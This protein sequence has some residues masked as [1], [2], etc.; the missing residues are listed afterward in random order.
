MTDEPDRV[1]RFRA[2]VAELR[3]RTGRT[4]AERWFAIGGLVLMAAGVVLG[5]VGYAASLD[6]TA[7]PGSNVDLLQSNSY[8][9]LAVIGVAVSVVGGFV[10]VR[11]S[12]A[13]FLR[14]WLL[15]RSYEDQAA[16]TSDSTP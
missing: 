10:F 1:E 13:R 4:Q 12:L 7:T 16:P 3:L 9:I 8:V 14:L 6:V 11:C 5:I 2:D 15:R